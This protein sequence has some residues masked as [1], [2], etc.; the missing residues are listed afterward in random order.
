MPPIPTM[1]PRCSIFTGGL[2]FSGCLDCTSCPPIEQAEM[3]NSEP[4]AI[5]LQDILCMRGIIH[6]SI[7]MEKNG[8]LKGRAATGR[9][10]EQP[11]SPNDHI[12]FSLWHDHSAR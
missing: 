11:R 9:L 3:S 1:R 4:S 2:D 10:P 6:V 5:L 7:R 12:G 8:S